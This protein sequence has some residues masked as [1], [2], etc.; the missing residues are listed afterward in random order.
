LIDLPFSV[1]LVGGLQM[2]IPTESQLKCNEK[3]TA[4]NKVNT[5]PS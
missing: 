2:R 3:L 5:C 1:L 4:A